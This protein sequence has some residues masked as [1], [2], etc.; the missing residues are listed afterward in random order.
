M[1][2][3]I[4]NCIPCIIKSKAKTYIIKKVDLFFKRNIVEWPNDR[5]KAA[6]ILIS[7]YLKPS[8]IHAQSLLFMF[9][10]NILFSIGYFI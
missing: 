10:L 5:I 7:R 6:K 1:S 2:T 4:L 3:V 9:N 8:H